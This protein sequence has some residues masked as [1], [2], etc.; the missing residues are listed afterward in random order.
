MALKLL[1]NSLFRGGAEKQFAALS[2]LLPADAILLLEDEV[3]QQA[4]AAKVRPLSAHNAATP[5]ALKTAYIPLY[6]R[7]LAALAGPGDTVLSFM[8]RANIVNVLAARRSGHR[9]VICERTRPSGEFSGLRG[10]LMRPLIK[11]YYPRAGAVVANSEGV[12]KD[13]IDNFSV[14]PEK[15]RVVHNGYDTA[16]IAAGAAVPLDAAWS[17]VYKRP[18]IATSGRL[19]AAKGQ[20]HLLR[21]FKSVKESC[22][23]AAL[24][25]VG[26]GEL[27]TCLTGTAEALGLKVFA[28]PGTPPPDADVYFTGFRPNPFPFLAKARLFAFT[29][30]WEGFPNALVEALACGAP[31]IAADCASGPREILA[32]RSA[33]TQRAAAPDRAEY[34]V[35]MPV[36]SGA[37]LYAAPPEP[38]ETAWAD[39]ILALLKDGPALENY[40][41]A[42]LN[43][44]RDFELSRAAAVWRELLG[45]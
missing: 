2:G 29:S 6:A 3:A 39:E 34:G 5:S 19:T 4:D 37:K 33:Y 42:G 27:K 14:P 16:A 22:P 35:L 43:R 44:A 38:A 40:S 45:L 32:P 26:N 31:V 41:R 8:E 1:I 10:A 7:R 11:R 12:R 21:I 36:L 9:A 30:L 18:V 23:D 15:I 25:L 13:L 20:W 17:A 28:G 24:V